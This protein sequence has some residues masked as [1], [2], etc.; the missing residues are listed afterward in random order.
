MIY[1][2]RG[3]LISTEPGFFVVEC[4]GVGYKCMASANTQREIGRLGKEIT[5]YTHM[6]VREDAVE[7]YGFAHFEELSCF[8]LLTTVNG[9]GTKMAISLL[10]ELTPPQLAMCIS[11]SDEK[12]LT[13]ASGVGKK[14]AQRII[15]ELKEKINTFGQKTTSGSQD[16]ST[17]LPASDNVHA[18][19]QALNVLGYSASDVL[20]ILY[21]MDGSQPVEVLIQKTLKEIGSQQK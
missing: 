8:R 20:P 13:R 17:Q 12:S 14:L 10:S 5:V 18:A 1:S 4:G 6:N 19:A 21:G 9:V 16:T 2:L 11:S 15:L 7:L 3:N